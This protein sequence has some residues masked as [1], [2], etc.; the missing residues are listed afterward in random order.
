MY[1]AELRQIDESNWE[2]FA[3]DVL[4]HL[5]FSIIVLAGCCPDIGLAFGRAG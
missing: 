1:E 4:F 5:G 2:L 3:Q